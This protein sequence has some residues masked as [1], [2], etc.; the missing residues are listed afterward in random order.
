VAKRFPG[1]TLSLRFTDIDLAGRLE[2][3]RIRKFDDVRFDFDG[4]PLRLYFVYTLADSKG[5][6]LAS[7]SE[8]LVESYY[9]NR[10]IGYPNSEEVSTLFYEKVALSRWLSSLTPSGSRFAGK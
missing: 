10:H 1:A 4:S 2:P 6:V 3:W 9:L 5:K 7:G 8:S